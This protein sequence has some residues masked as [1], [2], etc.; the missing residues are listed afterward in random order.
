MVVLFERLNVIRECRALRWKLWQCPPF[1][2]LIMGA[3][4]IMAMVATRLMAERYG[5]EMQILMVAGVT[6]ILLIVGNLII[7]GFNQ[8]AE[9]SR[10]KTEFVAIVSHQ[11]R[12]PLSVFRWTIDVL[13]ENVKESNDPAIIGQFLRTLTDASDN[14]IQIVNN[15]LDSSRIDQGRFRLERQRL[16]LNHMTER[17]VDFYRRYADTSHITI[18]FNA[19]P[20]LP[21]IEG[22]KERL[23]MVIQNLLDNAVH[24]TESPGNVTITTA[25]EPRVV[26]WTIADTGIGIP[27]T[28][29]H[30][31]F[32]KF[33]RAESARKFQTR[34]S[35]IGLF[36]ARSVITASGG[37]MGFRSTPG[38]GSTF[39]FTLPFT[40]ELKTKNAKEETTMKS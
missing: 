13:K 11:L 30:R 19:D 8:V 21:D 38:K 14:M 40:P 37:S 35:G 4:T 18:T 36:I 9:A 12:S 25:F 31:I 39:W 16:S 3:L 6:V 33:Y 29:Q 17:A 23:A 34:G 15:L 27:K 20:A 10:M 7:N 32:Q 5:E 24:Y 2:F 1:L 28:E 22:D 26:R